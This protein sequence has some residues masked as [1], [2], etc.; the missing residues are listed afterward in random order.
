MQVTLRRIGLM[1]AFLMLMPTIGVVAQTT[2]L[3]YQRVTYLQVQAADIESFLASVSQMPVREQVDWRLY[4]VPFSSNSVRRYNYVLLEIAAE[5]R[6]LQSEERLTTDVIR[7][8][9]QPLAWSVHSEIWRTRAT[10]YGA[11]MEYPSRYVNANFMRVT[12]GR[13]DDYVRLETDIAKGLHQDQVDNAR[14][15]GW[16]FYQLV[17][18]TGR[19]VLYQFVTTDYYSSI[20]QNEHNITRE[21]IQ[22]VH[23]DMDVDEFDAYADGIRERV[24]SDLWELIDYRNTRR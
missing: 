2:D 18:P 19:Q 5:F 21:I 17:F 20:E 12:G 4:Q 16:N 10:V 13:T 9:R 1:F 15:N 14:M 11:A 7:R 24:F 3:V 23:P 6:F 8:N 22:R